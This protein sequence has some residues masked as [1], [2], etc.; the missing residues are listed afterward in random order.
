MLPILFD[1]GQLSRENRLFRVSVRAGE[2]GLSP[3]S[4]LAN[5]RDFP[6]AFPC[7]F[8]RVV[9]PLFP[10]L[11][12]HKLAAQDNQSMS[13]CTVMLHVVKWTTHVV[14]LGRQLRTLQIRQWPWIRSSM[15]INKIWTH[16]NLLVK[17][18]RWEHSLVQLLQH[19]VKTLASPLLALKYAN[20]MCN[21]KYV[22]RKFFLC[23]RSSF[24]PPHEPPRKPSVQPSWTSSI[25]LVGSCYTCIS[26]RLLASARCP[27]LTHQPER[28][29][30]RW[31]PT[32]S[33]CAFN[34]S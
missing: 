5:S 12:D 23:T 18:F 20:G 15:R 6:R 22:A 11:E 4:L 14:V 3:V 24:S 31:L 32:S 34:T 10:W 28:W 26:A 19:V 33:I 2:F 17:R 27:P 21:R 16:L 29:S 9:R 8:A 25:V 30:Y 13:S 7:Y 1:C